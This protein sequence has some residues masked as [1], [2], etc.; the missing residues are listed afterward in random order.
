MVTG[1]KW[2]SYKASLTYH[3]RMVLHATYDVGLRKKV[4]LQCGNFALLLYFEHCSCA[5]EM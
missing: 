3:D 2:E 4:Q 1:G 5:C